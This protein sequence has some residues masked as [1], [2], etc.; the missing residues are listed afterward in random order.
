MLATLAC[1]D[2]ALSM[3]SG[4]LNIPQRRMCQHLPIGK[5]L[6]KMAVRIISDGA[7]HF[8]HHVDPTPYNV[9]DDFC[10][11]YHY[12][13]FQAADTDGLGER[14]LVIGG[15]TIPNA[16]T[17]FADLRYTVRILWAVGRSTPFREARATPLGRPVVRKLKKSLRLSFHKPKPHTQSRVVATTRDP[18]SVT[19]ACQLLPCVS[20]LHGVCDVPGGDGIALIVNE[21]PSVSGEVSELR[22][23]IGD[24]SMDL[25]FETNAASMSRIKRVFS[26]CNRIITNSYHIAYWGLL[27]GKR[28][29]FVGYSSKSV[30]L[31][32]LF[33]FENQLRAEVPRGDG[34]R[35]RNALFDAVRN[36]EWIGLENAQETKERFRKINRDFALR[37]SQE[38]RGLS[39][40]ERRPLED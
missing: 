26:S 14:C 7:V 13:D 8:A 9:G 22:R 2:L 18:S 38:I 32:R 23:V 39:V 1:L 28:I 11:P 33:G 34:V 37:L 19:P 17:I 16:D 40:I 31:L 21:N 10:A 25:V 5:E 35:F 27:S 3:V 36:P 30:E 24:Q 29:Q 12:F 20:C 6:R 4:L 15:G